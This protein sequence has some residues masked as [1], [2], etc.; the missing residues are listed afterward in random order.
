[1]KNATN[2]KDEMGMVHQMKYVQRKTDSG[3]KMRG[4]WPIRDQ[5]E[6]TLAQ[7]IQGRNPLRYSSWTLRQMMSSDQ[8]IWTIDMAM[9]RKYRPAVSPAF[10]SEMYLANVARR[11]R[12]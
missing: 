6:C 10:E 8:N 11:L 12:K 9:R 4:N 1:M 7:L 3:I 5:L 2:M